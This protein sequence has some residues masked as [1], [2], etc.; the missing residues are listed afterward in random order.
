MSSE[1]SVRLIPH[2]AD[3]PSPLRAV[4]VGVRRDAARLELRFRLAGDLARVRVPAAA[5][6]S[7]TLGLWEHTCVEAFVAADGALAY[8]EL[9]LSP[10][11]EWAAF[12][13]S[14]FRTPEALL[15]DVK[16]PRLATRTDGDALALDVTVALE[17]LAPAYSVAALWL[18]LSAVVEATDGSRSYWSLVHPKSYPD[19]HLRSTR[20]LRLAAPRSESEP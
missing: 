1:T 11:S 2:P 3:A 19:F 4:H 14:D 5:A 17:S 12:A 6:P 10:S 9:N 7:F 18:G 13:F 15:G 16:A 20:T 8:H